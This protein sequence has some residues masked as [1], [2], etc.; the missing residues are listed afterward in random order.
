MYTVCF[1]WGLQEI[2][3]SG[4]SFEAHRGPHVIKYQRLCAWLNFNTV[5]AGHSP[6][7]VCS[8]SFMS[9][10]YWGDSD[11]DTLLAR[12]RKGEFTLWRKKTKDSFIKGANS[13][14]DHWFLFLKPGSECH[15]RLWISNIKSERYC[16]LKRYRFVNHKIDPVFLSV[17]HSPN[18]FCAHTKRKF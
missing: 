7:A 10:Q 8:A 3:V 18:R 12:H 9:G 13:H 11:I 4:K 17:W 16:M 15:L 14:S 1:P 5:H 6:L 2:Y